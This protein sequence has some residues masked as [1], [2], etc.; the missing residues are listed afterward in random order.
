MLIVRGRET[1]ATAWE[2]RLTQHIS[3]K[4]QFESTLFIALG[5]FS[6]PQQMQLFSVITALA[7]FARKETPD[8]LDEELGMMGVCGGGWVCLVSVKSSS[9]RTESSLPPSLRE[10]GSVQTTWALA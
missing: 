4:S 10:G 3:T 8:G 5:L 1:F 2:P 7:T 9:L 6:V